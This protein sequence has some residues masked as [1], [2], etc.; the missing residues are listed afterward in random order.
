M[1]EKL[2]IKDEE[3]ILDQVY[4]SFLSACIYPQ[5]SQG[6]RGQ[7]ESIINA[8]VSLLICILDYPM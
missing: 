6:L 2:V 7:P 8:K 4:V 3:T 1:E 5:I